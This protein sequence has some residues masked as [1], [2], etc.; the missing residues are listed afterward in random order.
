M[1][2]T[3][4]EI[5]VIIDEEERGWKMR[6]ASRRIVGAF[7]LINEVLDGLRHGDG[8]RWGDSIRETID[9]AICTYKL[10]AEKMN[11]KVEKLKAQLS[12]HM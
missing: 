7:Q 12:K 8:V 9:E 10:E 11:E 4:K 1:G 5:V 3:D 2:C 6:T